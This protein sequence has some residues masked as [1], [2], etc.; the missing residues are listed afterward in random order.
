[1]ASEFIKDKSGIAVACGLPLPPAGKKTSQANKKRAALWAAVTEWVSGAGCQV[2]GDARCAVSGVRLAD[3]PPFPAKVKSGPGKGLWRREDVEAW[4][5]ERAKAESRKQK[6]EINGVRNPGGDR[7]PGGKSGNRVA[8]P[9]AHPH[10]NAEELPAQ[11]NAPGPEEELFPTL[12]PE[13]IRDRKKRRLDYLE[14]IYLHPG[15]RMNP[16]GTNFLK[17][18]AAETK[19]L[20]MARP[21][22]FGVEHEE[23]EDEGNIQQPTS[24]NQH[25][26]GE[27]ADAHGVTRPTSEPSTFNPQPSTAGEDGG[28]DIYGGQVGVAN[29]INVTFQGRINS[30]NGMV[31]AMAINRWLQLQ[32]LPT[33]CREAFPPPHGSGR[34]SKAK[35][36]AWCERYIVRSGMPQSL[37]VVGPMVDTGEQLKAVQ[38]KRELAE[39]EQWERSNSNRFMETEIVKSFMRGFGLWIGQQ[40]DRLVEDR[41]GVRSMV[42]IVVRE[43]LGSGAG[44]QVSGRERLALPSA[45]A[46]SVAPPSENL[47]PGTWNLE[48]IVAAIDAKLVPMLQAANDAMKKATAERGAELLQRLMT[49]R[50]EQVKAQEMKR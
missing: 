47:T 23:T 29:W 49:E 36:R 50:D 41:N 46:N 37:P 19:E 15:Q 21:H 20:K 7:S 48:P 12:T 26:L 38:L 8:A 27:N 18:S 33:G 4:N 17:L 30:E 43:V 42:A 14:D 9:L 6:A 22:L 31:S 45:V 11:G 16:M 34:F 32:Y 10:S 2:S 24:N 44:Y 28:P 13:E 35:V 3:L 1:M 5:R 40:Q 25:P 39:F